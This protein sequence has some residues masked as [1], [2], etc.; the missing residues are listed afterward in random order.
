M[1]KAYEGQAVHN[2]LIDALVEQ[3]VERRENVQLT[4]AQAAIREARAQ[5]DLMERVYKAYWMDEIIDAQ[6]LYGKN[7]KPGPVARAGL[8]LLAYV[9]LGYDRLTRA[10]GM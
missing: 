6:L 2:T 5:R 3:E 1:I 8:I 7:K 4:E 9:A 10:L